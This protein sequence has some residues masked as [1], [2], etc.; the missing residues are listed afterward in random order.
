ME[1]GTDGRIKNG[2]I[3][4]EEDPDFI[5]FPPLFANEKIGNLEMPYHGVDSF[6]AYSEIF[7]GLYFVIIAPKSLI[8]QLTTAGW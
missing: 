6:W 7:P 1:S 3:Q 8:M 4:I 5:E 2:M